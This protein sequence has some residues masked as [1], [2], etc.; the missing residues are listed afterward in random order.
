MSIAGLYVV[1][2]ALVAVFLALLAGCAVANDVSN[3]VVKDQAGNA[4][5]LARHVECSNRG[6]CDSGSGLC[7]C[8]KGFSGEACEKFNTL[9]L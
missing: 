5:T 2:W 1:R 7:S 4:I 9:Q 3:I 8:F 6:L